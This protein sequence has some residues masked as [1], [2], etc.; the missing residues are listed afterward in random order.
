MLMIHIPSKGS[1]FSLSIHVKHCTI[2]KLLMENE[3]LMY[4]FYFYFLNRDISFTM[5]GIILKFSTHIP[6]VLM[7]G[8]LSQIFYLALS[9]N[10][11][12]KNG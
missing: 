8:S 2:R 12:L 1:Y 11:I 3:N 5:Q 10:F 9:S 4:Y 6:K 7:E